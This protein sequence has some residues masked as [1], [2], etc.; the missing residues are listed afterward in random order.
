M[1]ETP[2]RPDYTRIAVLEHDLFGI[3]PEPGTAAALVIGLRRAGTCLTHQPVDTTMLGD[4][5]HV[6][7]CARCGTSMTLNEDGHWVTV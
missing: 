5:V 4:P 7:I 1:S 6:G 2:P 3:Q